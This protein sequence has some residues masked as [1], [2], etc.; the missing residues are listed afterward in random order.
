M[1]Y[2][3]VPIVL[4]WAFVVFPSFRIVVGIVA[5][6]GVGLIFVIIQNDKEDQKNREVKQEQERVAREQERVA[7]DAK[8]KAAA[9]A[10]KVNWPIVKAAQIE[11]R[12]TSLKSRSYKDECCGA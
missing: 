10:D 7:C 9:E 2:L 4:I 6:I 3:I 11:L 12:D 1:M 5:L 8:R